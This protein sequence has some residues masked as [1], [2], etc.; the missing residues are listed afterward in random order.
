[1]T[2]FSSTTKELEWRRPEHP[3]TARGRCRLRWVADFIGPNGNWNMALVRQHF[4]PVDVAE[5]IKIKPSTRN[6]EDFLHG[7][8]RNEGCSPCAM[9]TAWLLMKKCVTKAVARPATIRVATDLTGSSFGN[10]QSLLRYGFFHG[11]LHLMLWLPRRICAEE[12]WRK[13][14]HALC[15]DR[16]QKMLSMPYS[17]AH[18]RVSSGQQCVKNGPSLLK[19]FLSQLGLNGYCKLYMQ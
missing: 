11:S 17:D 18:M 19:A 9:R 5:I 2:G 14:P 3:F 1:M 13:I 16:N 8:R 10:V 4:L 15:V 12:I 7:T 6:Q